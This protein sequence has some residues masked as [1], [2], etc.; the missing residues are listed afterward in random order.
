MKAS[1]SLKTD[2]KFAADNYQFTQFNMSTKTA[3]AI[4]KRVEF[5]P[6]EH[7][8]SLQVSE[9]MLFTPQTCVVKWDGLQH[10]N[11]NEIRFKA[12]LQPGVYTS[13]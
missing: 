11:R 3:K 7:Q 9:L 12:K 4:S 13:E 1:T 8:Y 6:S 5:L 10:N 2:L